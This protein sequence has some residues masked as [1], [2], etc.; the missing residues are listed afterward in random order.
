MKYSAHMLVCMLSLAVGFAIG[1]NFATPEPAPAPAPSVENKSSTTIASLPEPTPMVNT[2][3]EDRPLGSEATLR[4]RLRSAGSGEFRQIFLQLQRLVP[5]AQRDRELALLFEAWGRSDPS[6]AL[7]AAQKLT[8]KNS[9]DQVLTAVVSGWITKEPAAAF[10]WALAQPSGMQYATEAI[11]RLAKDDPQLALKLVANA[12]Q[13]SDPGFREQMYSAVI[14]GPVEQ[15]KYDEASKIVESIDDSTVRKQLLADLAS[16]WGRYQPQQAAK[17]LVGYPEG[18]EREEAASNLAYNWAQN[19]AAA[20]ANFAATLPS[21]PSRRQALSSA[22]VVWAE[23]DIVAAS[24]WLDKFDPQPDNDAAVA[25]I[26]TS[27]KLV[28]Q[29]PD[30]AISWAESITNPEQR[31]DAIRQIA[32]QWGERDL[33][34]AVRYVQTAPQLSNTHRQELLQT[35]SSPQSKSGE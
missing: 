2:A 29:N 21:G 35:L 32:Y 8:D 22:V 26:A 15:G 25:T 24:N 16:T 30:I 1:R 4:D 5:S 28:S 18:A 20:A 19:D 17:W 3:P 14:R 10:G 13:Q 33:R 6:G 34:A 27:P 7:S 31:I 12:P 9:R 11:A 23:Q